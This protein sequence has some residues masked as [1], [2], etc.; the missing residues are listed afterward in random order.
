MKE[1]KTESKILKKN[2]VIHAYIHMN[3]FHIGGIKI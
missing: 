1:S 3:K 2:L